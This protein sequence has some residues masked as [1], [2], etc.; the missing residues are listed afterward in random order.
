MKKIALCFFIS[1][2]HSLNHEDIWRE[3]IEKNID[4]VEIYFHYTH[5][6]KI[7]SLWIQQYLLPPEYIVQTSY[8]YMVP[9]YVS[10]M[11]YVYNTQ[12]NVQWFCLLTE[13]CVPL[14]TPELFR[15]RF[16][17]HSFKSIFS[18]K[19]AWWNIY[20]HR[21]ANLMKIPE[22]FRLAHDPWFVI[23]RDHVKKVLAFL[24]REN[25]MFNTICSGAIANESIIAVVLQYF[26]ELNKKNVLNTMS[27]FANWA[28]MSSATSPYVFKDGS[29]QELAIVRK[30]LEENPYAIFLR[31]VD[32]D[33]PKDILRNMINENSIGYK[34]WIVLCIFNWKWGACI[35][36]ALFSW[37][38]I[39]VIGGYAYRG[40]V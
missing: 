10:M 27:T 24:K 28:N 11:S 13:S 36:L 2:D 14:I 16:F 18:W 38:Y 8:L 26:N 7:K 37:F 21:R 29:K 32:R 6:H 31:K 22:V 39:N 33:F 25:K 20:Y 1:G 5:K 15:W 3:W 19:K 12:K 23:C 9:A 35:L 30:G 17:R 4:I 34:E 40:A